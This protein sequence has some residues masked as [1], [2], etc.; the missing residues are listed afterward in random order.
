MHKNP[1]LEIQHETQHLT[2]NQP[3]PLVVLVVEDREA[4]R[5]ALCRT[6]NMAGFQTIEAKN[7]AEALDRAAAGPNLILLDV[8]LPDISG[9]EVC[10]MLKI[11]RRTKHIPV[12]QMS[13]SHRLE[14]LRF[15][16]VRVGADMYLHSP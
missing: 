3:K 2:N 9:I 4:Q 11:G 8:G 16:P 10:R 1:Q 6:L 12:I 13:A 14:N 15:E 5:Y 7:G